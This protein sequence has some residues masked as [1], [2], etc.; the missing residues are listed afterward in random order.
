MRRVRGLYL[1]FAVQK[2]HL[3]MNWAWLRMSAPNQ[4]PDKRWNGARTLPL[5]WAARGGTS[6]N[7][8]LRGVHIG[9]SP[10]RIYTVVEGSVRTP[11]P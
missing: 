3:E 2:G 10:K 9:A 6:S 7:C 5:P 4:W 11:N 1:R 8:C